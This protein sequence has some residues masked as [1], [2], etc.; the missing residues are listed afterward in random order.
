[1]IARLL[2]LSM[3]VEAVTLVLLFFVA[4]PLKYWA[5][6]PGPTS[7]V[8]MMHG[9]AFL[10]FVAVLVLSLLAR[11]VG[12]RWGALLFVGAFVPV[13]GFLNDHWLRRRA[14]L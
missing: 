6:I 3:L 4:M 14:V 9:I 2:R 11:V 10:A 1:M 7:V 5:D 12:V 8:G 13:L